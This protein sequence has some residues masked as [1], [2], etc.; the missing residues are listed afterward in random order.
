MPRVRKISSFVTPRS[1][2]R[3]KFLDFTFFYF[4]DID[5]VLPLL[6][7]PSTTLLFILLAILP[8]VKEQSQDKLVD[9]QLL[10]SWA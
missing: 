6:F 1:Y 4:L 8:D 7:S 3:I 2:I 5:T 10:L 9:Y